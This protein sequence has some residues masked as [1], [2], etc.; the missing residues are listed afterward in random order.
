MRV[1][2]PPRDGLEVLPRDRGR[3]SGRRS[4]TVRQAPVALRRQLGRQAP[5]PACP[6]PVAGHALQA[7]PRHLTVLTK[8]LF[9]SSVRAY[10]QSTYRG[11]ST[12]IDFQGQ[13]AIVTG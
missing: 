9:H 1:P 11:V 5:K 13:V 2:P 3:P 8:Y 4:T 12:L 7:S 10:R 6:M